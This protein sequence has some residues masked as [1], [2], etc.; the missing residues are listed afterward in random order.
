MQQ[1]VHAD[2]SYKQKTK[3]G[4]ETKNPDPVWGRLSLI[5]GRGLWAV[6]F[7]VSRFDFLRVG[8]FG[9]I[10]EVKFR[11]KPGTLPSL[12]LCRVFLFLFDR[13]RPQPLKKEVAG[14]CLLAAWSGPWIVLQGMP[15]YQGMGSGLALHQDSAHHN[16]ITVKAAT[17]GPG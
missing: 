8:N 13:L 5:G 15:W 1:L 9:R 2:C 12:G 11:A 3:Q 4:R 17:A 7:S 16:A 14:W 6:P 10:L